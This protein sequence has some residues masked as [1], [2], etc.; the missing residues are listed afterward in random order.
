MIFILRTKYWVFWHVERFSVWTHA[1]INFITTFS[2]LGTSQMDSESS[3]MSLFQL[4]GSQSL[5]WNSSFVEQHVKTIGDLQCLVKQCDEFPHLGVN[6]YKSLSWELFDK[7]CVLSTGES[8]NDVQVH[9]LRKLVSELCEHVRSR[10]M[11]LMVLE[12]LSMCNE[13]LTFQL[14]LHAMETVVIRSDSLD[15]WKQGK[16]H[17]N[18]ALLI[19]CT[20]PKITQLFSQVSTQHFA[21]RLCSAAPP[22]TRIIKATK[23]A[24]RW[25]RTLPSSA[26][27]PSL[28]RLRGTSSNN[29]LSSQESCPTGT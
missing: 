18:T 29:C 3:I 27:S 12:K 14:L 23:K 7:I 24:R 8:L 13:L 28:Q 16:H 19:N 2:L 26:N 20:S 21:R 25:T 10:E 17:L 6:V 11:F 15:V 9:V 5:T 1:F 4:E 22:V